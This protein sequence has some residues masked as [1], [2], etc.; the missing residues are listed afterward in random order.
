MTRDVIEEDM[1]KRHAPD[2]SGDAWN[3][4]WEA[5]KGWVLFE[6]NKARYYFKSRRGIHI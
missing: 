4:R 3:K 6:A 5:V 2:L 1:A